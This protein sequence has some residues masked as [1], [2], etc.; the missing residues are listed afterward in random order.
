MS[1]LNVHQ[2][3]A[4]RD[5]TE[6]VSFVD[7]GGGTTLRISA[8]MMPRFQR[9]VNRAATRTTAN[10]A[11]GVDGGQAFMERLVNNAPALRRGG[12]NFVLDLP[13][14]EIV[15]VFQ[16]TNHM[17]FAARVEMDEGMRVARSLIA[18][19]TKSLN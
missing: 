2:V 4:I 5:A 7:I 1:I 16:F 15:G 19:C 8:D 10:M 3:H 18:L 11:L 9:E 12:S 6:D 17:P 14:G 13:R